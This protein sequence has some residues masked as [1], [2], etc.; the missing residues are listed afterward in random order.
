MKAQ[1]IQ[2]PEGRI[3]QVGKV[4][5]RVTITNHADEILAARGFS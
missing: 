5:T 1:A 4:V 3:R 2:Q